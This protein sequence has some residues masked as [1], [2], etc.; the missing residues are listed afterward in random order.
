MKGLHER[1]NYHKSKKRLLWTV[2][3][4]AMSDPQDSDYEFDMLERT[5]EWMKHREAEADYEEVDQD[6][7]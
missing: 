5:A 3:G 4:I 2:Q 1:S 6:E 7:C